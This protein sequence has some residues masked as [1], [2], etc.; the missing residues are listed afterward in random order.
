Q[1]ALDH[2]LSGNS[3]M[4]GARLPERVVPLHPAHPHNNVM[5]RDVQGMAQ[6][7]LAGNIGRWNDNR[8]DRARTR[9]IGLEITEAN[10]ALEPVLFGDFGIEGFAQFQK[11][12]VS[13]RWFRRPASART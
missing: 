4:I 13:A 11:E 8:E 5:Q 12:S 2:V 10:P 9:G 7:K 1:L 3:G 6:V